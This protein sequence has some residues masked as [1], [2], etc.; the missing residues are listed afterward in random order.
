MIPSE[1]KIILA[2]MIN[3]EGL[4]QHFYLDTRGH[5]T[6]GIGNMVPS[7]DTAAALP[8]R[9]TDGTIALP[10]DIRRAWES[11][12]GML[13][14]RLASYYKTIRNTLRMTEEDARELAVW[15]LTTE[16]IPGASK[17][18]VGFETY[19]LGPKRAIVDIGYNGG[20]GLL[21]KF[22]NLR[23]CCRH[24]DWAAAALEC[25]VNSSRKERNEW[26]KA[27][28]LEAAQSERATA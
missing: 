3:H 16:F 15:R 25:Q 13:P 5:V 2:D 7:A 9:L 26:R 28:F 21:E 23:D 1:I 18:F 6:V 17:L 11:V 12:H 27:R 4:A 24:R 8:M 19:P 10:A 20:L 22:G 14:G